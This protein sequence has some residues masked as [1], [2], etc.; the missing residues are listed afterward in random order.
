MKRKVYSSKFK[1][2]VALDAIESKGNIDE[3]SE[4]HFVNA[5]LVRKWEKMLRKDVHLI[6]SKEQMSDDIKESE[7]DI[8]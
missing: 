4:R 2:M 8:L 6:F 5:S 1:G 3:V 7:K